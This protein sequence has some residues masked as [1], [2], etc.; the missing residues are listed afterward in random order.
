MIVDDLHKTILQWNFTTL[1]TP[2]ES[3]LKRVPQFFTS[4]DDYIDIFE[5]LLL[6]E[7]RA[8]LEKAKDEEICTPFETNEIPFLFHFY[9]CFF[10]VKIFVS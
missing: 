8:Q 6:E 7:L 10:F 3:S 1:H 5:P 2:N 9:C 4:V